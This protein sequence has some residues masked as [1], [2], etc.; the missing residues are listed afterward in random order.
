MLYDCTYIKAK[1]TGEEKKQIQLFPRGGAVWETGCILG[2]HW[3]VLLC[4][5]IV[6]MISQV[7]KTVGMSWSKAGANS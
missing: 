3:S 5:L 7:L 6:V 4:I 1:L 2:I